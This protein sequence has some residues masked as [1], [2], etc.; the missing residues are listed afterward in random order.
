M[1][2]PKQPGPLGKQDGLLSPT[3]MTQMSF[4][5]L[6][7]VD[8]RLDKQ[9]KKNQ[10]NQQPNCKVDGTTAQT[11]CKLCAVFRDNKRQHHESM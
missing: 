1:T 2:F 5:Q 10:L 8:S 9:K 3:N 4:Q 11:L 7:Q 6:G